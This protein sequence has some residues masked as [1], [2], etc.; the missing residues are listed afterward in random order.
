MCVMFT[1][2]NIGPFKQQHKLLHARF[3][4]VVYYYSYW[5]ISSSKHKGLV[6]AGP[7]IISALFNV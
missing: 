4:T 1:T 5:N 3:T 7:A 6:I 2:T